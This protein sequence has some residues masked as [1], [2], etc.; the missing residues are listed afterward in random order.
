[1]EITKWKQNGNNRPQTHCMFYIACISQNADS[2]QKQSGVSSG[3][4]VVKRE[5]C[6][7]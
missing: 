5:F 7:S 4:D 1:M 3:A 6:H 2:N